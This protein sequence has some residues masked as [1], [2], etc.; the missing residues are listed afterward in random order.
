[1]SC[2]PGNGERFCGHCTVPFSF[3]YSII[4]LQ[5][6]ALFDHHIVPAVIFA[7]KKR[8][9]TPLNCGLPVL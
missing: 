8:M 3:C 7:N 4:L 2:E 1:M 6:A 9:N 5:A